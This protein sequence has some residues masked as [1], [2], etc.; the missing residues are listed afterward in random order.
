M[1]L[2]EKLKKAL[3]SQFKRLGYKDLFEV[4]EVDQ[5]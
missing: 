1:A 3:E 4:V 2:D 5:D